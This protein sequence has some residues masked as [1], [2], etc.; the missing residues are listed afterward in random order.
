MQPENAEAY[1]GSGFAK[2]LMDNKES[3][4]KD[5]NKAKKMGYDDAD[6]VIIEYCNQ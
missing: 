3:G 6:P 1:Y 4:C 2:V 5:L